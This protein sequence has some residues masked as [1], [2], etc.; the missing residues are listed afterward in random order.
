MATPHAETNTQETDHLLSEFSSWAERAI[1]KLQVERRQ[2]IRGLLKGTRVNRAT[3][4]RWI[5]NE[6]KEP[7]RKITVINFCFDLGISPD[8]PLK[9]LGFKDKQGSATDALVVSIVELQDLVFSTELTAEERTEAHALIKLLL[10]KL[11][12]SNE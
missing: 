8:E 6:L 10:A 11:R 7:P 9:I 1:T 2:S 12:K 3:L 4:D 5:H